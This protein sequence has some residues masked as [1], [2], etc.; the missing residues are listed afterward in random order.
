MDLDGNPSN[1]QWKDDT[2]IC[3]RQYCPPL[4]L[5]NSDR[6]YQNPLVDNDTNKPQRVL[7]NEGYVFDTD[8][9]RMGNVKCGVIVNV[10][11][12]PKK[13]LS[14]ITAWPATTLPVANQA[15]FPTILS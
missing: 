7:C 2:F 5:V 3:K 4:G 12:T 1:N 15:L 13:A 6:E 11:F 9:S 8:S 10:E 14:P